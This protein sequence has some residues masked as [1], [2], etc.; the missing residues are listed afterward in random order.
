MKLHVDR[1]SET[2]TEVRLEPDAGWWR[3]TCALLPEL[4][5]AEPESFHLELRAHRMGAELYLEGTLVGV[6]ELA[7]GRCA[8]RYRQP[9]REGLRLVLEP[10]GERA[11]TDPEGAATLARDGVWLGEEIESGWF[12]GPVIDLGSH[13]REVVALALPVQP[14]CREECR[15]LCPRCGVDRNVEKCGCETKPSHSP[16]AVLA[17]LKVGSEG[18]GG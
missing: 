18:G 11:P 6:A 13:L 12:R 16:F 7:C 9:L 14:L 10:V 5:A 15:G 3:E 4:P 1:L 8:R 17:G 2:P